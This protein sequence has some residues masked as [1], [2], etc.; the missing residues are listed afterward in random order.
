MYMSTYQADPKMYAFVGTEKHKPK[1]VQ[2]LANPNAHWKDS[3]KFSSLVSPD[4][5]DKE[6]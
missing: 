1:K 4:P 2:A 3:I 6:M 5:T